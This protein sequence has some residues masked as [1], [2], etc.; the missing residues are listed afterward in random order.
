MPKARANQPS[1]YAVPKA[2]RLMSVSQAA[3]TTKIK[4][5][6][7][8]TASARVFS[9]AAADGARQHPQKKAHYHPIPASSNVA[10]SPSTRAA[11]LIIGTARSPPVPSPSRMRRSRTGSRPRCS[12]TTLAPGSIERWPAIR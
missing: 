9:K 2:V 8:K 12:S 6:P 11:D 4:S 3:D 7:P 10:T 5:S 1:V